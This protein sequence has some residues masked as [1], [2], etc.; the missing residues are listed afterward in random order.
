MALNCE[1]YKCKLCIIIV[2][3]RII[4]DVRDRNY[5]MRNAIT[6]KKKRRNRKE[7]SENEAA[8]GDALFPCLQGSD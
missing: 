4:V 3:I 7:E 8:H 6:I 2:D 1:I 5:T